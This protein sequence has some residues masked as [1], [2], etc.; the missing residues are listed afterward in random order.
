MLAEP[1]VQRPRDMKL[2]TNYDIEEAPYCAEK[3]RSHMQDLSHHG[4]I[5]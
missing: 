2:M 1:W 3:D 5:R 4:N